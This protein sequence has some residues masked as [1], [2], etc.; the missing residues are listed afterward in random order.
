MTIL[1]EHQFSRGGFVLV[2]L[3][4]LSLVFCPALHAQKA[5]P[6]GISLSGSNM[7]SADYLYAGVWSK[8]LSEKLKIQVSVEVTQGPAINVQLIDSGEIDFGPIT[9]NI[10]YEGYTGT[11]WTKG[12]KYPNIRNVLPVG[13]S[14]LHW[15]VP[16]KLPIQS[17]HDMKGYDI[18]LS[19]AG[20]SPDVFGRRLFDFLNIKPKRIVNAGFGDI[21]DQMRDGLIAA[22]AAFGSI[23]N[24]SAIEFGTTQ[25]IRIIGVNKADA[26][27][28]IA[29]NPG[30]SVGTI[31]AGTYKGQDKPVD[32]IILWRSMISHNRLSEDFIY[33][34]LKETF[35]NR[36]EMIAGY[37]GAQETVAESIKYMFGDLPL[38]M[39]A[40]KY[41]RE[42]GIAIP[43][44]ALPP[45]AKK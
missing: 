34:V 24:P 28:F 38:H 11:G 26:E 43:D 14:Y 1:A 42:K 30:I 45:E 27:K 9:M 29:K 32:T 36:E 12:K 3:M 20:S 7:G 18:A 39:G 13:L 22:S 19:G 2:S 5:W 41:Y 17:I 44:I 37:K 8:I 10:G 31:P 4:V 23:P 35:Q 16:S 6:K 15:W 33:N 21:N 25:A 40:V